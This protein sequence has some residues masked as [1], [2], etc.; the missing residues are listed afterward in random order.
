VTLD[1]AL[2]HA[3]NRGTEDLDGQALTRL[4]DEVDRL[5]SLVSD[6]ETLLQRFRS[7]AGT[8]YFFDV[9]GRD[10]ASVLWRQH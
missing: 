5:K 4:A 7:T 2:E 8:E 10:L 1:N 3:A 6:V 9:R